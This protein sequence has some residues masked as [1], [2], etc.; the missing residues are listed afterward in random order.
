MPDMEVVNRHRHTQL[1]TIP[2]IL[3][4]PKKRRVSVQGRITEVSVFFY[5]QI[6]QFF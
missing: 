5:V 6:N 2:D 4:S 1:L 3:T